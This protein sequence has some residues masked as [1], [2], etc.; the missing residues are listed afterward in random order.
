MRKVSAII[1]AAGKGT[2]MGAG[3]SKQFLQLKGKPILFYTLNAFQK[4]SSIDEIILVS[5]EEHIEYCKKDIVEKYEISKVS[6]VVNGGAERQSSVYNG[7]KALKNCDIVLIHDAARP[8]IDEKLIKDGVRYAEIYGA[9]A[10][11]V[12]PKDT[13]KIKDENGFSIETPDRSKLFAV[14]TPQSFKYELIFNCHKKVEHENIR[15]TDDTMVVERYGNKVYLYEGSYNNIKIT[16][17][18]DLIIGE[19]ILENLIRE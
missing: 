17:P 16:T 13:I 11:G 18:E 3:I 2:R 15:V 6:K 12:N 7:L 1:V 5:S 8:F 4:S 9:C 10:C 14:Q 19:K